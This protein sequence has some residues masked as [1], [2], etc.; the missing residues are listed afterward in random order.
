V[1]EAAGEGGFAGEA[2][3]RLGG[4]HGAE[5]VA[6]RIKRG[7]P[8]DATPVIRH[9]AHRAES[10]LEHPVPGVGGVLLRMLIIMLSYYE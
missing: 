9:T 10:V 1:D 2:V 4:A 6:I 3:G 8:E 5:R 7:A